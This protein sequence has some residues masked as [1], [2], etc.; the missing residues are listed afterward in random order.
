[1]PV[2]VP[3]AVSRQRVAIGRFHQPEFAN[4]ARKRGL[5]GVKALFVEQAL[6]LLLTGDGPRANKF[7]NRLMP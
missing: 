7:Q 3:I 6:K 4:V 2:S 5:P 1:M